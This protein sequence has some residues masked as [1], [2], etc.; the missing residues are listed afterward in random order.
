MKALWKVWWKA[1]FVALVAAVA[2]AAIWTVIT[3]FS[4]YK[5]VV[6]A[7][8]IGGLVGVSVSCVAASAKTAVGTQASLNP[9]FSL[10]AG[11]VAVF[12]CVL[13]TV[14]II[15]W[16]VAFDHQLSFVAAAQRNSIAWVI[17]VFM[18][19]FVLVDAVVFGACGLLAARLA[20][21]PT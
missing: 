6:F 3:A 14:L 11:L 5:S 10:L 12:G 1:F 7:L 16:F 2:G 13:G 20:M 17:G 4:G 8:G 19:T 18:E 9:A 21:P 15:I